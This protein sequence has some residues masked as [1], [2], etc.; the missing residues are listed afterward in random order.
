MSERLGTIE[1]ATFAV[2]KS[3]AVIR[4]SELC[5]DAASD[6]LRHCRALL[7][8]NSKGG[9]SFSRELRVSSKSQDSIAL[10]AR[11][12]Q[13]IA[14]TEMCISRHTQHIERLRLAGLDTTNAKE[15]RNRTEQKLALMRDHYLALLEELYS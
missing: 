1:A 10:L 3:R 13:S 12:E 2:E 8:A 6:T 14:M 15:L 11:T 9:V 5:L 4:K 7:A